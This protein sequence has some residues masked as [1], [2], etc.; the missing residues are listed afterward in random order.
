[1]LMI[2]VIQPYA[3]RPKKDDILSDL[4]DGRLEFDE[5]TLAEQERI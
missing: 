3:Y 4:N 2:T 1:M 5:S